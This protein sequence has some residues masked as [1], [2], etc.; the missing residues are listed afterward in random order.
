M[1]QDLVKNPGKLTA[2]QLFN[3]IE[4]ILILKNNELQDLMND[5]DWYFSDF[6]MECERDRLRFKVVEA[7]RHYVDT[8]I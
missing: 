8:Q 3:T 6:D 1:F 2:A 5:L 4:H 7:V